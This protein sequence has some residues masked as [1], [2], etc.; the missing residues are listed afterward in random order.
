[1]GSYRKSQ[2]PVL[3]SCGVHGTRN[4]AGRRSCAVGAD[5]KHSSRVAFGD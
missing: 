2:Q 4:G 5:V 3:S 1:V